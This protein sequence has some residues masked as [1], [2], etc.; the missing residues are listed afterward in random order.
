[1]WL[2]Y[3]IGTVFHIELLTLMQI[4][5]MGGNNSFTNHEVLIY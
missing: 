3:W 2:K 5:C 4:Y 1:M